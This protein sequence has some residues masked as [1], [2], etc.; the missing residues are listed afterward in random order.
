ML[1]GIWGAGIPSYTQICR[2]LKELNAPLGV[3]YSKSKP[4]DI[5]TN[6]TGIK[7]FNRGE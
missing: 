5:A 7:A 6:S 1:G 2:R 3:K 4:V